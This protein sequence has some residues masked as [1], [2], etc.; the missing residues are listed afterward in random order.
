MEGNGVPIRICR[1]GGAQDLLNGMGSGN[2]VHEG[3]FSDLDAD[4]RSNYVANTTIRGLEHADFILIVGAN[5]RVEA[6][7]FNAR[8]G[9]RPLDDTL[10]P[11]P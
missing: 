4:A 9:S 6:P 8:R 5:P 10:N 11:K 3:G 1:L 7:V 2:T